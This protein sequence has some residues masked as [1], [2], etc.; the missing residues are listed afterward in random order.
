MS[1]HADWLAAGAASVAVAAA[2]ASLWE[3]I[4]AADLAWG[5]VRLPEAREEALALR[6]LSHALWTAEYDY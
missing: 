1:A 2:V 5:R 4:E 6:A 3:A